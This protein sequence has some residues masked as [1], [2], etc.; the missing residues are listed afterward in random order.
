MNSPLNDIWGKWKL[1]N[2]DDAHYY[3]MGNWTDQQKPGFF[4]RFFEA[5]RKEIIDIGCRLETLN[6]TPYLTMEQ[7]CECVEG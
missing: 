1:Q 5:I 3:Q 2:M 7:Q 6:K 4:K